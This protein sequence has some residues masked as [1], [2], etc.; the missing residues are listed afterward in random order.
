MWVAVNNVTRKRGRLLMKIWNKKGNE[1][2]QKEFILSLPKLKE[3]E[4]FGIARILNVKLVEN[5]EVRPFEH[6]LNDIFDKF[7]RAPKHLQKDILTLV[8][9]VVK[10]SD[11]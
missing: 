4:F 6:I 7:E 2:R 5:Q 11:E 10:G 1:R 3:E 8:R 9:A